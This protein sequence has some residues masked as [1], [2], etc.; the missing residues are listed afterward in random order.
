MCDR[1][2]T[3]S[4]IAGRRRRGVRPLHQDKTAALEMRD[5]PVG[6]DARHGVVGM[7]HAP[8]AVIAQREGQAV[9]DFGRRWPGAGGRRRSSCPWASC[10]R[11]VRTGR[12]GT[13]AG[14][15]WPGRRRRR[16]GTARTGARPRPRRRNSRA[17][18]P[19]PPSRRH[20]SPWIRSGPSAR[21]TRWRRRRQVKATGGWSGSRAMRFDR[22]RRIEQPHRPRQTP[23]ARSRR[24][25]AR[26]AADGGDRPLRHVALHRAGAPDAARRRAGSRCGP[27]APRCPPRRRVAIDDPGACRNAIGSARGH[28]SCIASTPRPGSTVSSRSFSSRPRWAA[29]RDGA[30]VPM[31]MACTEPSTRSNS[32]SSRRAPCP[33]ASSPAQTGTSATRR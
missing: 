11:V 9:G 28:G 2:V 1:P 5:Q 12:A 10:P 32:R 21:R 33:D 31:R 25:A 23:A 17:P 26:S 16:G 18:L 24:G 4:V 13:S 30:A 29:W 14:R 27:P 3:A 7:M 22:L 6:G 19:P 15:R 20:H 8:A